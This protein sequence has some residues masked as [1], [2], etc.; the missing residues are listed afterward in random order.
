MERL[1]QAG[2]F[3]IADNPGV[4]SC[5]F[6]FKAEL[7]DFQSAAFICAAQKAEISVQ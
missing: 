1:G 5:R 4:I 7:W 2:Y 6:K 3:R